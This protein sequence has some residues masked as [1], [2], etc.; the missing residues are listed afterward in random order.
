MKNINFNNRIRK[1]DQVCVMAGRSKG[2]VSEV[3]EVDRLANR[4]RVK[5]ANMVVRHRKPS[6][7]YPEGGKIRQEAFLHVSNVLHVDPK[8][9]KPSRVGVRFEKNG[10]KILFAKRSGEKVRSI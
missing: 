1:G 4:L 9:G 10:E 5:G 6:A 8:T 7:Q 2:H 3:L